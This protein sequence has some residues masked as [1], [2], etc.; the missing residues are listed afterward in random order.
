MT[1]LSSVQD[2]ATALPQTQSYC[3]QLNH[4]Q[5]RP[6]FFLSYSVLQLRWLMCLTLLIEKQGSGVHR[7]LVRINPICLPCCIPMAMY[8]Y[9]TL[10]S[11]SIISF[12]HTLNIE[13]VPSK[14]LRPQQSNL[15]ICRTNLC[16]V[17]A[18][19]NI[20]SLIC[21]FQHTILH[22]TSSPCN[23]LRL[24]YQASETTCYCV[25]LRQPRSSYKRRFLPSI[26]HMFQL[27]LPCIASDLFHN[28]VFQTSI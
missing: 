7:L 13:N 17:N 3:D 19:S 12:R 5:R 2:T 20:L 9:G 24:L 28:Q 27:D 21:I 26:S 10:N 22:V 4:S 6:H 14:N 23:T 1:V 15:E 18:N 8:E 11:T 25:Y 16:L